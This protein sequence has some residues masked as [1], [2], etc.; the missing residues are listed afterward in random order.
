M[1]SVKYLKQIKDIKK[2]ENT[3]KCIGNDGNLFISDI[4]MLNFLKNFFKNMAL[5]KGNSKGQCKDQAFN[6]LPVER[7]TTQ[8][9]ETLCICNL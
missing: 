6:N 1:E 2:K 9:R 8:Q 5:N 7:E 3:L 4:F